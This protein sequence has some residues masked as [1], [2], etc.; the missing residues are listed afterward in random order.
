MR[1]EGDEVH[2]VALT[3][4]LHVP[5]RIVIVDISGIEE[6]NTHIIYESPDDLPLVPCVTLLY[7]PGHYDIIYKKCL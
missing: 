3:D 7:R 4:V 6:P 2:L 5:L 1:A